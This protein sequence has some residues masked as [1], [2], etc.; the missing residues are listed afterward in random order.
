MKDLLRSRS[1]AEDG[2][3]VR[4][5]WKAYIAS[6]AGAA[7]ADL[8]LTVL[9]AVTLLFLLNRAV[10]RPLGYEDLRDR[11]RALYTASGL[12]DADLEELPYN[13]KAYDAAV[14]AYYASLP[15]GAGARAYRQAKAD[16]GLFAGSDGVLREDADAAAAETFLTG[17]YRKAREALARDPEVR[18]L[19]MKGMTMQLTAAFIAFSIA[20]SAFYLVIPLR[21]RRHQTL[22]QMLNSIRPADYGSLDPAT[23]KQVLIRF[24]VFAVFWFY[25]PAVLL[26]IIGGHVVV[27]VAALVIFNITFKYH[28]GI[29]D[30]LSSTI[31]VDARKEKTG[32]T[33]WT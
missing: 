26:F 1:G 10:L 22:G 8:L 18:S 32:E 15:D 23:K 24:L 6:R 16:S 25:L 17:E 21:T 28:R 30:L 5:E 14:T 27:C 4:D 13:A 20:L 7:I 2:S 9:T 11:T 33:A 12:Y 31:M 19:S 29:Q 3:D